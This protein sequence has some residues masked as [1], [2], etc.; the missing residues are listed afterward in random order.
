MKNVTILD[1][2]LR[3]GGYYNDWDFPIE[4]VN[5]YL[6]AMKAAQVDIVE[7]GFRFLSNNDFKGATAFTRDNYLRDLIIPQGLTVGVMINGSDM[8]TTL[9]F[10]ETLKHF[11]PEVAAQTPVDLVRF[12]CHYHE[13]ERVLPAVDWLHK[14]GYRVGFNLMQITDRTREEV[15]DYA[16]KAKGAPVEA[17]YFADSMGSMTPDDTARIIHWIREEWDGPIGVHTHDNMGLALANTLRAAAEGA[18]WLD[19]TVT[20]MGRGPG[21]ARTEELVIE[22]ENL[23]PGRKAN[24]VP[25][26]SLI[27]TFFGPMKAECGW[28]S[29]PFYYLSGKYGIHP[30]YVQK[31]LADPRY[32]EEDV[33]VVIDHLRGT[34]GKKFN[35]GTME[36]AR[37]FYSGPP[38][39]NWVP[40]TLMEGQDVLILGTGPSVARHRPALEA[41]IRREKPL[42]LALNTQ[43]VIAPELIDLRAACNPM[44]LLADAEEHCKLPQPLITPVSMLP[45]SFLAAIRNKELLDFGLSIEKDSFAF[46]ETHCTAPTSLVLAYALAVVTSGKAKQVLLTGFDGYPAGDTRNDEIERLFLRFLETAEAPELISITPTRYSALRTS[47][48]YGI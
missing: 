3:D 22:A 23:R 46:G 13:F 38:Q 45:E 48:V 18:T 1:C 14:C 41:Y 21:N 32:D 20:G 31:M 47:S 11:F 36:S 10:E 19:A 30:T 15:L 2:T 28:G 40:A 37:H 33:L 27:R 17:L 6:Q 7:L 12:A 4:V 42:V 44:R 35:A 8:L 43:T 29:N 34:D 9:G 24:L 26:M 39:G 25:L 16:R 5:A